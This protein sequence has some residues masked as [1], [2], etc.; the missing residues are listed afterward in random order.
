MGMVD[1]LSA[2]RRFEPDENQP[3]S[4]RLWMQL[5]LRAGQCP[6]YSFAELGRD[7]D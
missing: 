7:L 3:C 4:P 5:A 6:A 1:F 2:G